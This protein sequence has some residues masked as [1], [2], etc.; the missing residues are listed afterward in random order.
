MWG[1]DIGIGNNNI[2]INIITCT[3]GDI[4]K[5]GNG[6]SVKGMPQAVSS[7]YVY[8]IERGESRI[9][10]TDGELREEES[11]YMLCC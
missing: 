9:L 1:H 4:M 6:G 3:Y 7:G 10:V 5:K 8:C 11:I 2:R